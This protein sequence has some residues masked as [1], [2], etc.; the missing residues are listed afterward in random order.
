V[1]EPATNTTTFSSNSSTAL[2]F[3]I[4]PG[5]DIDWFRLRVGIGVYDVM[6][7]STV[8]GSTDKANVLGLGFLAS[9]AAMVWRPE[10]FALGV[11]ARLVALQAPFN[12]VYQS[13]WQI[14]LTGRWDFARHD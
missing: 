1:Y 2:G 5:W 13:T 11:E 10:P 7:R 3:I 9:A 6:V 8:N 14:G 12:G 4:G